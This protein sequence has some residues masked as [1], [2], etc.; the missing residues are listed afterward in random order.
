MLPNLFVKKLKNLGLDSIPK[1]GFIEAI[2]C[3]A[4]KVI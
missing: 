4:G 1:K 2:L 3:V